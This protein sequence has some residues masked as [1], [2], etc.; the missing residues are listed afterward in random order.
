MRELIILS[1]QLQNLWSDENIRN[2]GKARLLHSHPRWWINLILG[3]LFSS[4][5]NYAEVTVGN[6]MQI[7]DK[8]RIY[9]TFPQITLSVDRHIYIYI[10]IYIRLIVLAGHSNIIVS[11]N[12]QVVNIKFLKRQFVRIRISYS[13][14]IHI[15]LAMKCRCS[16][17][18]DLGVFLLCRK[19]AL[20]VWNTEHDLRHIL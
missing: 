14:H 16:F 18:F 6:L 3:Q 4:F 13:Q 10:Y 12:I 19:L 9:A 1:P 7:F 2:K 8:N 11:L 17:L 5:L 20:N 15:F